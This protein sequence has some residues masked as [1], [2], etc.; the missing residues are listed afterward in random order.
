ML[1][2]NNH[3]NKYASTVLTA[4]LACFL[5]LYTVGCGENEPST[6]PE[7]SS[8]SGVG[9]QT[10]VAPGE[11]QI[12]SQSTPPDPYEG[13]TFADMVEAGEVH[14]IRVIGDSLTAGVDCDNSLKQSESRIVIYSDDDGVRYEVPRDELSWATYF[15]AWAHTRGIDHFVNAGVGGSTMDRLAHNSDSWLGDGATVIFVMLG[16]NDIDW[17]TIDQYRANAETALSAAADKCSHL[18]VLSPP[19]NEGKLYPNQCELNEV[20]EVLTQICAEHG[21]EHIS[22]Y[23]AVDPTSNDLRD[24]HV[25]PTPAGAKK[26]WTAFSDR[27][28]LPEAL[29]KISIP[30][31]D[32]TN[33]DE[34]ESPESSE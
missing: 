22:L 1:N 4:F 12:E 32:T 28:S 17:F 24:D 8:D 11:D 13:T 15:R 26:L 27:M 16:T 31:T 30:Q 5:M 9:S 7:S 2:S 3:V 25:H 19:N 14:S 33:N 21:W 20:D 29:W 34:P 18:V 10:K 6:P 23:D